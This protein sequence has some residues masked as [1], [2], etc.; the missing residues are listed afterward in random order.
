M[1]LNLTPTPAHRARG[2]FFFVVEDSCEAYDW[3]TETMILKQ[4]TLGRT[5]L[6]VSDIGPGT[7][8]IVY[9]Y[10][11]G[12]RDLPPEDEVLS[13]WHEVVERGITFID[14]G[15][16]Y[17][18]AEERI[19]KSGVAKIPG[20]IVST[21]CGHVMDKGEAI[22]DEELAKEMKNDVESS[23][24]KLGLDHLELVQVHGGT[25][26]LKEEAL[27][28]RSELRKVRF[29]GISTRE[30]RRRLRDSV[31]LDVLS[32]A[33]FSTNGWRSVCLRKLESI[34]SASSIA[35]HFKGAL[36]RGGTLVACARAAEKNLTRRK[37]A[38]RLGTDLPTWLCASLS[39]DSVSTVLVGSNK[40]KHIDGPRGI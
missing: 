12:P 31:R 29:V 30:K 13:F 6:K 28:K 25:A 7:T 22:T 1:L 26:E 20:V 17:G 4:R 16:F 3:R 39:D 15:S 11:I 14:T 37:N 8:V 24:Q 21:K 35:R 23:L 32:F 34:I 36:T 10:G 18:V 19:G 38:E 9:V 5:G 2:R 40:I 33:V 27:S